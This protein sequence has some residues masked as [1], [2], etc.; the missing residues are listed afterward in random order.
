MSKGRIP[1]LLLLC[2]LAHRPDLLILDEPA[3]GLIPLPGVRSCPLRS[4]CRRS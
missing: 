4:K 1:A 3:S 2:A